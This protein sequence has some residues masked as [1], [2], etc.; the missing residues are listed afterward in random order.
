[1][2]VAS[3]SPS[4]LE[5]K[6]RTA[7]AYNGSKETAAEEMFSKW[8]EQCNEA[9]DGRWTFRWLVRNIEDWANGVQGEVHFPSTQSQPVT[10]RSE[11]ILNVLNE[12]KQTIAIEIA[13]VSPDKCPSEHAVFQ[14]GARE[15]IRT[16]LDV[17]AGETLTADKHSASHA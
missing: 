2:V 7:G 16:E 6:K 5:A 12:G 8:Q 13:G 9:H 11:S 4:R 14:R 3:V 15:A 10:G 1:M 17:R